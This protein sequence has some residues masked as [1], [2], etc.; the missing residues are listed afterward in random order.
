MSKEYELGDDVTEIAARQ[1]K[2]TIVV[3]VRMSVDELASIEKAAEETG[4][5]VSQVIRGAVRTCLQPSAP[6]IATT[7]SIAG[8]ASTSFGYEPAS[9]SAVPAYATFEHDLAAATS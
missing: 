9:K 8:S 1:R 4:R 3:S 6:Q 2:E 7:I 5:S